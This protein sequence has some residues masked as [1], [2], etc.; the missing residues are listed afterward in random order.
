MLIQ[1]GSVSHPE[2]QE[3]KIHTLANA[4][5]S[6]RGPLMEAF[7]TVELL[8]RSMEKNL[9]IQIIRDSGQKVPIDDQEIDSLVAKIKKANPSAELHAKMNFKIEVLMKIA[10]EIDACKS[11]IDT[12]TKQAHTL[13]HPSSETLQ[14][15]NREIELL[16]LK[17]GTLALMR[18]RFFDEG[19]ISQ[20][21]FTKVC[22]VEEGQIHQS[23]IREFRTTL[24]TLKKRERS[25]S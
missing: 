11:R 25:R 17:I 4:S 24:K 3:F 7:E 2:W 13:K 20:G 9:K 10:E 5:S 1:Y 6:L 19:Y 14:R 18:E 21:A 8:E 16:N 12:L 22:F 23:K 15:I